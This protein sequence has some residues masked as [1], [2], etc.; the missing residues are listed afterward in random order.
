MSMSIRC[1]A[2]RR[3][4]KSDVITRLKKAEGIHPSRI[5][6]SANSFLALQKCD[7]IGHGLPLPHCVFLANTGA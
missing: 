4:S 7:H 6:V 1:V 3:S 2:A 5:V